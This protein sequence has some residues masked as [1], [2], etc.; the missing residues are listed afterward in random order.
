MKVVAVHWREQSQIQGQSKLKIH[1][2]QWIGTQAVMLLPH[3][4]KIYFRSV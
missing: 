4:C 1:V 3:G 2:L